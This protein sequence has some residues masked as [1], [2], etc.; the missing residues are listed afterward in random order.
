MALAVIGP[1][2]VWY[3]GEP[4]GW[5]YIFACGFILAAVWC[6]FSL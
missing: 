4:L 6:V 2:S 1:F 3:L 5:K